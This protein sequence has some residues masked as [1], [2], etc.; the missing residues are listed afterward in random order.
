M[1]FMFTILNRSCR[2]NAHRGN[3]NCYPNLIPIFG[4]SQKVIL[5][6]ITLSQSRTPKLGCL[7]PSVGG[8]SVVGGTD[9]TGFYVFMVPFSG[10]YN[11]FG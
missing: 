6:K 11:I 2:R 10:D 3:C 7:I 9:P 5:A 8:T 4:F 1:L